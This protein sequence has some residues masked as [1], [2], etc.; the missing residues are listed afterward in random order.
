MNN[1]MVKEVNTV[2]GVK[3][4]NISGGFGVGKKSM[5]AKHISDIHEKP[6]KKVNELI[7]NNRKRFKDNVDLIDIKQVGQT[8]LFLETGILTKAQV[9]NANNIYLLSE[10]GYA[11]LIKMFDDDK[12]WDLYDQ[13]LDEY[14]EM[15]EELSNV[16]P[17]NNAP[18]SQAEML[19]MYAQQFVEQEKRMKQIED[20]VV[21]M[22]NYL[23]ET[24][25][26]K[27]VER[28][29]NAYA[30]RKGI[31]QQQ[32]RAE[33]YKVIG[34]KYGINFKQRVK[35]KQKAI[36]EERVA[37]GKKPY[38]TSTLKQKYSVMDVIHEEGLVKEMMEV[39]TG[40]S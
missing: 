15:R 24:P 25:D 14:F 7:N 18:M 23:T 13:L 36:Q 12:S 26:S 19:V 39:L 8:D 17:I 40:L 28:E 22:K 35:N 2:C 9:G 31:T 30:R 33:V 34:D 16:T 10:R 1:L 20:N 29:I 38:S 27:K 3:I 32:A 5:L 37:K 4:P 6:L 11:K 21:Q